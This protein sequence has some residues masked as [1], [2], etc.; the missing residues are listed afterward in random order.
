MN[1]TKNAI[2]N[3]IFMVAIYIRLSKEDDKD[4]ESESVTNQKVLLTKYVEENGYK[5]YNIYVDDGY[6]G[7]N[8]NRPAFKEMIKD[9][10]AGK[11]NMVITKDL[12]RLGR[13]YIETGE[14][15]EKWFPAHKVRYISVLDNIDT[16]LD[17]SNNEI[18]PFK[19]V[20]N[21]MYSRENSKKIKSHLRTMQ[22]SGKWVGGCTPLGY[23]P[24]PE[25]KNH[26][27]INE[28]EATIVRR[29]FDLALKGNSAYKIREI[30][31]TEQIP[32]FSMLRHR[33]PADKTILASKGVWSVKTITGILSNPLYTGDLVQNRRQRINFKV[34]KIVANDKKDW[35]IVENSHNPIVS[36]E[37]FNLVQ[38]L[39]KNNSIRT[40]KKIIRSLDGLLYCKE[41]GHR[42]TID[43]PRK[44]GQTYIACNYYRMY[45][46]LKLCTSHGFNYD[47]L[48]K[49]VIDYCKAIFNQIINKEE[50]ETEINNNYKSKDPKTII[51]DKIEKANFIQEKNKLKL[52]NMYLDK[53]D[54]KITEEM[55]N[56]ISTKLQ[57]EI[58]DLEFDIKNLKNKLNETKGQNTN[59]KIRKLIDEF[60][61]MENPSREIML[62][63]I[64]KIEVYDNKTLDVYFNFK[65]DE[66]GIF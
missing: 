21:D 46:K 53:L 44:N 26:L 39:L 48:E 49:N 34:R 45:S 10:E 1:K 42:I 6:T 22:E 23:M 29:I 15:L 3:A 16:F 60:L 43:K 8:F 24:N 56:R 38:K 47:N 35:I 5:V 52:D 50:L 14:Y 63:L 55:Y 13:D 58:K 31:N 54:G 11:V 61:D 40:N 4:G 41:C 64:K 28:E 7:T 30:F 51:K 25:D 9:I 66:T 17:S 33:M 37:K 18:A 59:K 2:F 19:A 36:K 32:T 65:L 20:I 12:S 57:N 62:R 27:V